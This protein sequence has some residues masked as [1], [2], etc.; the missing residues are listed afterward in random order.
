[1]KIKRFNENKYCNKF[2]FIPGKVYQYDELP[3]KIKNDI[4]V[5]F[6][7]YSEYGPEDYNY[8]A[9]LLEPDDIEEY[10]VNNFGE[11]ELGDVLD[12]PYVKRIRKSI[13]EKGL[14]YPPVGTEGNHR[15]LIFWDMK[16]PL[17]YL[18]MELKENLEEE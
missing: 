5:Q 4:D 2:D 3:K 6:E 14:D 16:K 9:K 10:I 8:V 17:P 1:M 18:E 7:D 15:A 12:H 11:Y 13:I